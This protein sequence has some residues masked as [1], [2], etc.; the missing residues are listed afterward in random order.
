MVTGQ[1]PTF[2]T[3]MGYRNLF[4]HSIY[5]VTD[6]TGVLCCIVSGLHP[7]V[8]KYYFQYFLTSV[9]IFRYYLKVDS[10]LLSG[11]IELNP[12]PVNDKKVKVM[13]ININGLKDKV[14]SL[15]AECRNYHVIA[16]TETKL[17]G[18][19]ETKD[20]LMKGFKESIRKDR[21]EDQGGGI[22]IYAK[23]EVT[24]HRRHDLELLN[25]ESIWLDVTHQKQKFTIG[26]IYRPPSALVHKWNIIAQMIENSLMTP[27]SKILIVGDLNDD[28]LPGLPC[29][30]KN[31]I[32]SFK[33]HQL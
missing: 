32:D 15:Y 27:F 18:N 6:I 1:K 23:D 12:G 8:H 20:I 29:H 33:L 30:L 22:V 25:V 13:H 11:D 10:L 16:V 26:T 24:V 5:M 31:L 9:P 4:V 21:T 17:S 19:T 3:F 7:T 14:N 2:G 28:L